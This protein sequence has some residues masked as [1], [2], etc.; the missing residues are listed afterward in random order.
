MF[1]GKLNLPEMTSVICWWRCDSTAPRASGGQSRFKR[2]WALL[3]ASLLFPS[4]A[5]CAPPP[6]EIGPG[7]HDRAL[8]GA[9]SAAARQSEFS[10]ADEAL[11]AFRH[12][13]FE[14]LPG[15]LGRGYKDGEAWLA[16]ELNAADGTASAPDFLVL[17]VG[18]PFLDSVHAYQTAADGSLQSRGRAGDQVPKNEITVLAR[19]PTFVLDLRGNPRSTVL[20]HITTRS[21]VAAIPRL[22]RPLAFQETVGAQSLVLGGIL[23]LHV[24]MVV[25]ALMLYLLIREPVYLAWLLLVGSTTALWFFMDGLAYRYLPLADMAFIN[26]AHSLLAIGT[27]AAWPLYI[28]LAFDIKS[29]SIWLHRLFIGWAVVVAASMP[30]LAFFSYTAIV[31]VLMQSG[32]P[33]LVISSLAILLQMARGNREAILHG[34]L[35]VVYQAAAVLNMTANLGWTAYGNESLYG[36]QIAGMLNFLSLQFSIWNRVRQARQE[37]AGERAHMLSLLSQENQQLE[38]K[39]GARTQD[40]VRALKEVEKA[41]SDQRQLLSMASHEFR[42]PAAMI[43]ASL[44]SLAY[45]KDSVPP[46]VAQRLTNIGKASMRLNDLAN[47]LISH[48]RMQELSMNPKKSETDLCELVRGVVR[49]Y[50]AEANLQACLPEVAVTL[51]FDPVLVTIA[52]HNLIDNALRHNEATDGAVRITLQEAGGWVELRVADCGSGIPDQDKEGVFERF[53]SSRSGPSNGLGL[54]IVRSVAR[55]HGGDVRALDNLPKGTVM[56]VGFPVAD[57][58]CDA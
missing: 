17:E 14:L 5:L 18:P 47:S 48:D 51:S 24:T 52:L 45:L 37:R 35:F 6:I 31:D 46:E 41:E 1:P 43:K 28:T 27:L 39:I 8:A 50:P 44:D 33:I 23:M 54:S 58:A 26:E 29:L 20:L 56:V 4:L 12:G 40:L 9:V 7:F 10:S 13:K 15:N 32:G 38:E 25:V 21:T 19:Q 42:T 2:T 36:W 22:Y 3:V 57:R 11:A 34:P 49:N 55:S 16:F 53:F 30:L